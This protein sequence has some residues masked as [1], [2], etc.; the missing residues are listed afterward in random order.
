[1]FHSRI[2]EYYLPNTTIFGTHNRITGIEIRGMFPIPKES[3]NNLTQYF[4]GNLYGIDIPVYT[5]DFRLIKE[6]SEVAVREYIPYKCDEQVQ[7]IVFCPVLCLDKLLTNS[8]WITKTLSICI[9]SWY[10]TML[11]EDVQREIFFKDL[12]FQMEQKQISLKR[13]DSHPKS[14]NINSLEEFPVLA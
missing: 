7:M 1:M 6:L 5:E 10:V 13:S 11:S 14:I 4:G 2:C 12:C 8:T 9:S 3:K